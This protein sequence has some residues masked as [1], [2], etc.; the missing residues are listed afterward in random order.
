MED[1]GL[2]R[3]K[4]IAPRSS[5]TCIKM[6]CYILRATYQLIKP[7]KNVCVN[8]VQHS[9]QK[10]TFLLTIVLPVFVGSA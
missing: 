4:A 2:S 1:L 9:P 10:L 7:S 3:N 5:T 6:S 8:K